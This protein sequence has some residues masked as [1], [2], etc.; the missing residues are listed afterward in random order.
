MRRRVSHWDGSKGSRHY[1]DVSPATELGR[2]ESPES[3]LAFPFKGRQG[4]NQISLVTCRAEP[5]TNK[6]GLFELHLLGVSP[7][8]PYW[9]RIC[10]ANWV[11]K[12]ITGLRIVDNQGSIAT[13]D[14]E[15]VG[16]KEGQNLLRDT[17]G[18]PKVCKDYGSRGTVLLGTRPRPWP[19]KVNL[20][21]GR[22][23]T[24]KG[25]PGIG[26]RFMNTSAGGSSTVST[27][28]IGK[29]RKIALPTN[30]KDRLLLYDNTT[31]L[32]V[33]VGG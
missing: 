4:R 8:G 7:G 10:I 25:V 11:M 21:M 1:P 32:R 22:R 26:V 14:V 18:L 24:G 23:V 17:T 15:N 5:S 30:V 3:N 16:S 27:D 12:W 2:G 19:L 20:R 6:T 33:T 9:D 31:N 28:G 29:L 13:H